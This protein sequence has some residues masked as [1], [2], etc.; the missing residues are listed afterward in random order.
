M[1]A[2]NLIL[3][4]YVAASESILVWSATDFLL[5]LDACILPLFRS[6]SIG[7]HSPLQAFGEFLALEANIWGLYLFFEVVAYIISNGVI[8]HCISPQAGCTQFQLEFLLNLCPNR[9][10][11]LDVSAHIRGPL[12]TLWRWPGGIEN[13]QRGD[14]LRQGGKEVSGLGIGKEETTAECLLDLE[15]ISDLVDVLE[16]RV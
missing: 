13:E 15:S 3:T 11:E 5:V 16:L 8:I 10:A 9:L 1:F 6:A 4:R 7:V 2:W 14:G 12:L